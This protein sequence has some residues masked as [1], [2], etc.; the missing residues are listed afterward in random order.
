M[1]LKLSRNDILQTGT[2]H[3][4]TMVLLPIGS[5][6]QQKICCGDDH[7]VMQCISIK[8][9]ELKT[10]FKSLPSGNA[11][12]AVVTGNAKNQKDKIFIAEVILY[13]YF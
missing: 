2:T 6:K 10:N 9:G 13:Y 12:T 7:G 1:D 5:N 11:V 3:K 4:G 8:Q